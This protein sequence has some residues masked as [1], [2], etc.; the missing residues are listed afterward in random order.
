M[1]KVLLLRLGADA[2]VPRRTRASRMSRVVCDVHAPSWLMWLSVEIF[3]VGGREMMYEGAVLSVSDVNGFEW[4]DHGKTAA[5][6]RG[7]IIF[8]PTSQW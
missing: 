4:F 2:N 3:L 7:L 8:H 6:L 5:G 1:S